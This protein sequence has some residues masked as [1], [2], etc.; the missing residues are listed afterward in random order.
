MYIMMGR[1]AKQQFNKKNFYKYALTLKT[2]KYT[3]A[4]MPKMNAQY[5]E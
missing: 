2:E 1:D 5:P 4:N 3:C